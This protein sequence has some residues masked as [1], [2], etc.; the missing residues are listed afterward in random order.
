[1][2][3]SKI[4]EIRNFIIDHFSSIEEWM[5][6]VIYYYYRN[7]SMNSFI[8]D[9]FMSWKNGIGLKIMLLEKIIIENKLLEWSKR[10]KLFKDFRN[11]MDIRDHMAHTSFMSVY[12]DDNWKILVRNR[13]SFKFGTDLTEVKEKFERIHW[14]FYHEFAGV[15]NWIMNRYTKE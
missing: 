1:M 12:E 3:V 14:E 6:N 5:N 2:D 13:G 10:D 11:L 9:I 8:E 4:A 7:V 15:V